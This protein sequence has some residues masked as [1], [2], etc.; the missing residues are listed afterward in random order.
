ML[1]RLVMGSSP[2]ISASLARKAM[3]GIPLRNQVYRQFQRETRGEAVFKTR[4]ERLAERQGQTLKERAMA[5]PGPNGNFYR[6]L[7]KRNNCNFLHRFSFCSLCNWK[8][9]C[10]WSICH[11]IRSPLL[12]RFGTGRTKQYFKSVD[13]VAAICQRQNPRHLRILWWIGGINR[14]QC[15]CYFPHTRSLQFGKPRWACVDFRFDGSYDWI[16]NGGPIDT[17]W[18]RCWSETACLGNTLCHHGKFRFETDVF[19]FNFFQHIFDSNS[20]AKSILGCHYSSSVGG[21]RTNYST[22]RMVYSWNR[23]RIVNSSCMRTQR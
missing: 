1:S 12:L 15:G 10:R 4:S 22:R 7:L 16:R 23:W 9:S 6:H 5:P 11:W 13:A 14:S 20:F 19:F 2:I 21:R 8:R 18:T 3:Q 17:L